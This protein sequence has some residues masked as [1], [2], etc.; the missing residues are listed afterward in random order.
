MTEHLQ[1]KSLDPTAALEEAIQELAV[2]T[3]MNASSLELGEGGSLIANHDPQFKRIVRLAHSFI[4]P[5]FS[6]RIRSDQEEKLVQLKKALLRARDYVQ[7]HSALIDKLKSG[8]QAQQKLADYALETIQQYNTFVEQQG[9]NQTEQVY[10]YERRQLL[11]DQ[12]IVGN[13]IKLPTAV[14]I[15]YDSDSHVHFA[16]R[17]LRELRGILLGG[18][19]TKSGA[20]A[21][22]TYKKTLQFMIDTFRLK[23]IRMIQSHF[24][25]QD[26]VTE[27]IRLI[28]QTDIQIDME[29]NHE[30]IIMRQLVEEGPGSYVLLTGSYKK[31]AHDPKF[32]K[33]PI[34]ENLSMSSQ[35]I[36][37]GYPYP[38]QH[39]GWA[40]A[41]R[42]VD[43]H[44]LRVDQAPLFYALEQRR[45]ELAKKMLFD[46]SY[47]ERSRNYTRSCRSVFD[48]NRSLFL[49]M[50]RRLIQALIAGEEELN[51]VSID[52]FFNQLHETPSPFDILSQSQQQI[53]N[54]FVIKPLGMLEEEWLINGESILRTGT[55]QERLHAA[56]QKLEMERDK[57]HEI[58]D[59]SNPRHAFVLTVGPIIGKRF[60]AVA[61][62]YLSEKIGFAPPLL[63][64]IE[65][66][67]QVCA[68]AQLQGFVEE[69]EADALTNSEQI[70]EH[71][72]K[73]LNR[74]IS[75]LEQATI[76]EDCSPDGCQ[77]AISITDELETYFNFRFF[78]S[79]RTS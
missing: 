28:K 18:I 23:A 13:T 66:K 46:Q 71:L 67:L 70:K 40:L 52:Q 41:D 54:L 11:T 26:S 76:D 24:S 69:W 14:S 56:Q 79:R 48:E 51:R 9:R 19:V 47:I 35:K 74:D 45:K 8:D 29:S 30:L 63:R 5:Y 75:F 49:P 20:L 39:G 55:P 12:E 44:P 65:R 15:K 53:L 16:H 64:D 50:H 21:S 73:M 36:H 3:E 7:S 59:M 62:Q 27:V 32:L 22:S 42:W 33:M 60:E 77:E 17:T 2:F 68:F 31:T 78:D 72:I 58:L 34:L 25:E 43:A 6:D 37:S 38:S 1:H 57:V 61:L 4:A 10:N